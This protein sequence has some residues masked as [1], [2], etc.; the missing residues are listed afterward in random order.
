MSQK[1]RITRTGP[2][3]GYIALIYC[4][5][6][7]QSVKATR[8]TINELTQNINYRDIPR[9]PQDAVTITSEPGCLFLSVDVI[10]II[11]DD[12]VHTAKE[13]ALMTTIYESAQATIIAARSNG[14]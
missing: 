12:E 13:I 6:E 11:Q 3:E 4:W 7:G 5:G 14:R 1:L 10:F 8:G 9:T 2:R